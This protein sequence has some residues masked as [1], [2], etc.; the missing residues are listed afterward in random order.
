[1]SVN[2]FALKASDISV[3]QYRV[4]EKF[5]N[6]GYGDAKLLWKLGDHLDGIGFLNPQAFSFGVGA[7][8]FD[9]RF[10]SQ[11]LDVEKKLT[12]RLKELFGNNIYFS[13]ISPTEKEQIKNQGLI[14]IGNRIVIMVND[15]GYI[16]YIIAANT[17]LDTRQKWQN[18]I[19][20]NYLSGKPFSGGIYENSVCTILNECKISINAISNHET[21]VVL[22][23]INDGNT[24]NEIVDDYNRNLKFINSTMQYPCLYLSD[25]T[26]YNKLVG[27]IFKRTNMIRKREKEAQTKQQ[28]ADVRDVKL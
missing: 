14:P 23:Y 13:P 10:D 16:A 9:P 25:N 3:G 20:L 17:K 19:S 12:K 2:A 8:R 6:K 4:G 15:D 1:V 26:A 21:L 7:E 5:V 27:D 18:Y 22:G 24:F 11:R 28:M